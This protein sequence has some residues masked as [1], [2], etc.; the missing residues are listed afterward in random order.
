[1]VANIMLLSHCGESQIT[2]SGTKGLPTRGVIE[3]VW[4]WLESPSSNTEVH[5][6]IVPKI[7][8]NMFLT[9]FYFEGLA[10]CVMWQ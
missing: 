4:R 6:L 3:V 9:A 1:M 2:L 8:G 5:L 7:D 10:G